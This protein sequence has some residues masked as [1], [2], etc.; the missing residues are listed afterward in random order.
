[1]RHTAFRSL[2]IAAALA[3]PIEAL[4]QPLEGN[5]SSGRQLA[6]EICSGCHQVDADISS[7]GAYPPSLEDIAKLPSTTA[8]SLRAFLRSSH[9][10][11]PNL[12]IFAP[13]IDDLIVYILSLKQQTAPSR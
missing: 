5:L 6:I 10:T 12:L 9:I 13:D 11:M 7:K 8:L 3:V 2:F 4:A 1:M